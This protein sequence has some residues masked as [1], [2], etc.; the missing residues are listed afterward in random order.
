M[1]ELIRR[2]QAAGT[3]PSHSSHSDIRNR[4]VQANK[5]AL[6]RSGITQVQ[7]SVSEDISADET[8]DAAGSEADEEAVDDRED[9]SW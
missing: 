8:E 4:Q 3:G 2:A 1:R 6:Q 9:I 5:L 7:D